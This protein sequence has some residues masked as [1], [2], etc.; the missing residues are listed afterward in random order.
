[1]EQTALKSKLAIL[2]ILHR[3]STLATKRSPMWEKGKY[4]RLV[5]W[6]FG[7]LILLYLAFISVLLAWLVREDR[8]VSG[9]E[10]MSGILP[11]VLLA[12]FL[13][14]FTS[15]QTPSQLIKPYLLVPISKRTCTDS[16]LLETTFKPFNLAWQALFLPY[17]ILTVMHEEGFLA[18]IGFILAL[19][20][21]IAINSLWYILIHTLISVNL[22]WWLL[23]I[24]VYG[25]VATP[26]FIGVHPG[27]DSFCDLYASIGK[28]LGSHAAIMWLCLAAVL[29][30]AFIIDRMVVYNIV[31]KEIASEKDTSH[32]SRFN[33]S[34]SR[35]NNSIATFLMLD[36]ASIMRNKNLRKSFTTAIIAMAAISTALS[37]TSIYDGNR[38]MQIYWLYYCFALFPAMFSVKIMCYEGNYIDCLL[39]HRETILGLLKAKYY[40]TCAMMLLPFVLLL[41]TVVTNIFTFGE[42][43]GYMLFA[44]GVVNCAYFQLAVYN[45]QTS[46]LNTKLAGKGGTRN[47]YTQMI[48]SLLV[49][50]VPFP[51]IA[52][53]EKLTSPTVACMSLAA[54]GTAFIL[55]SNF[56]LKDIYKRMMR[57][58]YT[59]LESFHATR[60]E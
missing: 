26:F 8:T 32:S 25:L 14:R 20:I 37:F 5:G 58:K 31:S 6:I 33:L 40:S 12:D 13:L 47:N 38:A 52:L 27:I 50:A 15:Q 19:Q 28:W 56:W 45:N 29:T 2:K 4:A 18:F 42:L 60:V 39:V 59:N 49:L 36:A 3:H 9:V 1:M 30:L 16:F 53:M 41:P 11:F 44:A 48:V 55:T 22:A 21:I 43:L 54:I 10:F 34:F 7:A 24:A 35:A 23:P 46:P 51:V 57:R 17:G